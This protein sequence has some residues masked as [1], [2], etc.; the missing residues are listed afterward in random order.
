MLENKNLRKFLVVFVT[1][2]M[3]FVLYMSFKTT[4][5]D[6]PIIW[7]NVGIF[8]LTFITVAP[9]LYKAFLESKIVLHP[10]KFRVK[11]M[12]NGNSLNLELGIIS[13][14][15]PVTLKNVKVKLE[16]KEINLEKEF[17]WELLFGYNIQMVGNSKVDNYSLVLP[18]Y[19][20]KENESYSFNASFTNEN[21]ITDMQNLQDKYKLFY[22][23]I[24]SEISKLNEDEQTRKK[25]Y[26]L[27]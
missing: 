18:I 13:K 1:L 6:T 17:N 15:Q 16:N 8:C 26:E 3:I 7:T 12:S 25:L 10:K 22:E 27:Y 23:N 5:K 11:F 20:I 24:K 19:N 21:Q 2:F 9:L 4:T 14:Y